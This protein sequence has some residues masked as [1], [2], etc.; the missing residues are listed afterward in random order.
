M[1]SNSQ[2]KLLISAVKVTDMAGFRKYK[3]NLNLKIMSLILHYK[4]G[5]IFKILILKR[6]LLKLEIN[7]KISRKYLLC[8][9]VTGGKTLE[10][11]EKHRQDF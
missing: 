9:R 7:H 11:G 6:F 10:K 5:N 3:A 4:R 1:S 2:K 8:S